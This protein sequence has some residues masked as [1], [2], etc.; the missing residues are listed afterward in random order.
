MTT[1]TTTAKTIVSIIGR[2]IRQALR[3]QRRRDKN[4]A[5]LEDQQDG[6]TRSSEPI[7]P[8]ANE[9]SPVIDNDGMAYTNPCTVMCP[10]GRL[11]NTSGMTLKG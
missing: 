6:Q 7:L 5:E 9:R 4:Q 2:A 1:I 11:Q 3:R 8:G 10:L